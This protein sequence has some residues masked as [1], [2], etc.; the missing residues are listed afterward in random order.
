MSSAPGSNIGRVCGEPGFGKRAAII[1]VLFLCANLA[2]LAAMAQRG[3]K[4][5]T[6]Q[7]ILYLL[8]N[9]VPTANIEKNAREHGIAFELTP[10]TES[11][12]RRA[13]AKESLLQVLRELVLHP[14]GPPA[15]PRASS[16]LLIETN[17]GG[18]QVYVDDEPVGT[19]SSQGRLRLSQ[20]TPGE[21]RVRLSLAGYR[22]HEQSVE[23][24]AGQTARV[25]A[26]LA[27]AATPVGPTPEPATAPVETG[28]GDLYIG[29]LGIIV[30]KS[31][32][33][34]YQV[35]DVLEVKPGSPAER[36]GL[37]SATMLVSVA[38]QRVTSPQRLQQVLSRHR[39]GETVEITFN[40]GSQVH[41]TRA[42]LGGGA[43]AP[44][45][46]SAVSPTSLPGRPAAYAAPVTFPVAHDHGSAGTDYCVG[47]MAI[48]NGLIQYRSTNGVHAFDIPLSAVKEA[49][50]NSVYLAAIGAFHI[51]LKK[52]TNYNF[53]VI[54]TAGQWRPPD[55]LLAAIDQAM[56]NR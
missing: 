15:R 39:P 20:F 24:V 56:G 29:A 5:F 3:L 2:P 26:T 9:E 48:G 27:A 8:K 19:T 41:T 16:I 12:L 38:G 11:E 28:G 14:A 17:P 51:K 6:K 21:H 25:A 54:N 44:P 34:D 49:K 55:A 35:V 46:Y 43:T 33:A 18:V 32:P 4:P 47:V 36:A 45:A 13:G 52:G 37:H 1:S 53:C 42:Q 31:Q 40:D 10:E 50:R 22:D 23:L 30:P 7:D